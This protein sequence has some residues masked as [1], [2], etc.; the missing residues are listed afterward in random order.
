LAEDGKFLEKKKF[1]EK[2]DQNLKPVLNLKNTLICV[3][4]DHPTSCLK[5]GHFFGKNPL[6]IFG[7]GKDRVKKFSE[8][9]CKK[10]KLGVL[11]QVDL[12]ERIFLLTRNFQKNKIK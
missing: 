9:E 8:K 7:D 1:I 2:I 11:K 10:G 5:K 4:G 12:M 6:L 3:T